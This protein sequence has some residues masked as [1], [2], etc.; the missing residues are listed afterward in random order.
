MVLVAALKT[1]LHRNLGEDDVRVATNVANR[2]RAG[3][4]TLIGPLVN[5]VVLRTNLGGDP[6]CSR[7]DASRPG[8][9]R[10]GLRPPGS[11]FPGAYSDA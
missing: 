10:G 6:E 9:D 8:D 11:S 3:T 4:K 2:N 5:T 7:G 1:L